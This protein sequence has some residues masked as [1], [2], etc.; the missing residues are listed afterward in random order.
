MVQSQY[1]YRKLHSTIISL[2]TGTDD[3]LSNIDS[4]KISLTL[5]L[6]HKK[7]FDTIDHRLLLDNLEANGVK[8][9]EIKWFRPYLNERRQ[10]CRVNGHTS[11][12]M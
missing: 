7:T 4:G 10:F 9:T 12:T 6:D 5:F 2:I 3:W 11:K 1:A 8:G